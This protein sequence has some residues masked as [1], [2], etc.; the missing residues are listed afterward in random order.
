MSGLLNIGTSALLTNQQVLRT[1][2]NNI[3]NVNTVGY[4]R[5]NVQLNA[6]EGVNSSTGYYGMGVEGAVVLRSHNDML[7][8]QVTLT[9]SVAAS[10]ESR[11]AQLKKLED[12][13]SGG[14]TGLGFSINDMLNAFSDVANAPTDLTART[15]VLA[16]ADETAARFRSVTDN[17]TNLR[18]SLQLEIQTN[19][20]T[21]NQL[22]SQIADTNREIRNRQSSAQPPNDLL[23][24]RDELIRQLNTHVQTTS[25]PADDG[26]I[27]IFI[28][29]SQP[30]VLGSTVT[31]LKLQG[32]DY[33]DPN[34]AKLSIQRGSLNVVLDE[35]SLGGGSLAG[36]LRFQNT[37]LV[38][39]GNLVGRLAL[40][41]GTAVNDQH[42]LGLDL[43]GAAAGNLFKL[44]PIP[45]G[46]PAQ[47]N[48]GSASI[49]VA[50]QTTPTSGATALAASDYEVQFS[51]PA[52]GTIRR[53]SDGMTTAFGSV[54]IQIDGLALQV[55]GAAAAGDR[56]MITP[57]RQ[58]ASSMDLT[59]TSPRALAVASPIVATAGLANQGFLTMQGL[60]AKQP[61]ANL[62]QAVTLTFTGPGTFDVSGTGT[63]NPT[64][65]AYVPGQTINYNGWELTLKG[66]PQAGDTYTVQANAYP[67]IDPGNAH[68][69]L[70][71][72]DLALFD[73]AATTD[74]YA[75]VMGDIAVRVQSADFASSVSKSIAANA[76]SDQ[77]SLAGVNLDEEAAR[78]LQFQ[79]AYQAS[80][81]ILQV[82]QT[83]FDSLLQNLAR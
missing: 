27:G 25:I 26:S 43:N 32:D 58:V 75:G 2:G 82:S 69:M 6:L 44:G 24:K 3:A 72:R 56:F 64:G 19:V 23:D 70:G 37:D 50:V 14:Q 8:R 38:D 65:V 34:K 33:S 67:A 36:L 66:T 48:T 60:V 62:T 31:P 5:Q 47:N 52:A 46:L 21:V 68:A 73:G 49:Q 81:K 39:A 45:D 40:G 16:R 20:Q 9:G 80:A 30:L 15:V 17:L 13:F 74:G 78:M 4:S 18:S 29:G 12:L 63:G 71:I 77:A 11:L 7:T 54:P 79:Q 53:V 59:F 76:A 1:T 10:D 55:S 51:G 57:Y 41:L 61:D 22:A 42:S 35:A 28:G 83:L